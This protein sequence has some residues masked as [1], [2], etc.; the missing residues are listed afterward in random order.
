MFLGFWGLVNG[1]AVW[2]VLLP[3]R[4]LAFLGAIP[5]PFTSNTLEK[6]VEFKIAGSAFR[7][8][9]QEDA[10]LQSRRIH[11]GLNGSVCLQG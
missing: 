11:H 4:F 9:C 2:F 8:E 7:N 5:G 1:D 6:I 3:V 10:V